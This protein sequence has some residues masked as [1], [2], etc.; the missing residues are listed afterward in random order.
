MSA[1][2]QMP[3]ATPETL[4]D[5]VR[6]DI[7]AAA[8]DLGATS[9]QDKPEKIRP[10]LIPIEATDSQAVIKELEAKGLLPDV[11]DRLTKHARLRVKGNGVEDH[12]DIVSKTITEFIDS[13]TPEKLQRGTK[14]FQVEN[15][16]DVLAILHGTQ[17]HK[18]ADFYRRASRRKE[19]E[20]D[21][22]SLADLP[23]F[24][25]D[26]F[27]KVEDE[28]ILNNF[29]RGARVNTTQEIHLL[30]I[31]CGLSAQEVAAILKTSPGATRV[32]KHRLL[33]TLRERLANKPELLSQ[34]VDIKREAS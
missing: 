3:A 2:E 13:Y 30:G 21:P 14:P 4:P 8:H 1:A 28:V 7:Y 5:T 11:I 33:T 10:S 18:I 26:D 12:H 15:Y 6:P 16:K 31:L 29:M 19:D 9:L 17:S 32:G 20:F 24:Y 23:F 22:D 25:G 34:D 27:K